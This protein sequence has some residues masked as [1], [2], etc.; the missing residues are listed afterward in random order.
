[1]SAVL[2]RV[3]A[4]AGH[5]GLLAV[6]SLAAALLFSALPRAANEFTDR[7]LREDIAGLP[8]P[9]RDLTFRIAVKNLED[10]PPTAAESGL[11]ELEGQLPAP[12]PGLIGERWFSAMVGPEGIEP[13][14]PPPYA[15]Q[16]RP[17]LQI[18]Y[19]GGYD[20]AVR[21]VTGRL[22]KPG[23]STEVIV[24]S[25]AAELGKLSAGSKLKLAS[26]SGSRPVTVVGVFTPVDRAAHFWDGL[27]TVPASC[28]NPLDGLTSRITM[29]TD[30]S[31]AA[32]AG[33]A[34]EE[35]GYEWRFALAVERLRTSE[36]ASVTKAVADTRRLTGDGQISVNTGLDTALGDFEARLRGVRALLAV[37]Q[38][39]LV[40]TMLGLLVLAARLMT[41]RRR[42]EFALLRA[43]GAGAGAVV[44][45]TL[46]ETALVVP[47]AVLA[48]WALALLVPGRS[49][50]WDPVLVV[51]VGAAALFAAPVLAAFTRG[52]ART[53]RD[54]ARSRPSA[55][56]LT[57]ELFV[58][59]IAVLG[60][61]L[62]RRRGLAGTDSV[63]P[64]LVSVPV[65]LGLAAALIAVRLL[66]W[67]LRQ[68]GRAA[69]RA[70]G[71]VPFLGLAQA[72]RGAPVNV[73]PLAVLV[74][75]VA[76]GV[77]TASVSGTIGAARDQA[78]D[79]EIAADARVD[80]FA[81]DPGTGA[82]LA[83]VAGVDSVAP[84]LTVPA[85]PMTGTSGRRT[86]APLLVVNGV[87]ATKAMAASGVDV[88]MPDALTGAPSGGPAPA[89]VSPTVAAELGGG[90]TIDVQGRQYEFRV[91]AVVDSLPMLDVGGSRFIALPW[92]ALPIPEFQPIVPTRFLVAGD[93][94]STAELRAAG[95]EG[96]RAYL[97]R[98]LGHPV[99]DASLHRR[100]TV[101]TWDEYRADLDKGGVNGVLGFFYAA[102]AAG[103][104]VLA[105]LAVGLAVLADAPGRGRT[106][107]R[108]RTMGLSLRQGRRLLVYE[109]VP[110]VAVAFV[111]GGSV[112]VVLPGLLG[113]ALGLD[114]FTVGV[115]GRI[116]V[117][118]WLPAAA[119][120]LIAAALGLAMLV[121]SMA[122]RRM[123]LGEVL[124]LGEEN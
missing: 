72:G 121:E 73:G 114:G 84:A 45:R 66:P 43:R 24:D 25:D 113:P 96:Q 21:M 80:G 78:T 82:R 123:R 65:L 99:T 70:R 76:T 74:V 56:R 109:L 91:A 102:G 12:L 104:A 41:D 10:L 71:A 22:P 3:R 117:D 38:A 89:V 107:S 39:G 124:R 14:G 77:F 105:L 68:V 101:T 122:N 120:L 48:G 81:F 92:Q 63:D 40:A 75:A 32:Q 6:L 86:Q 58:V 53:R 1:M 11:P 115:T 111:A 31:G 13:S 52:D 8:Y 95:D 29:L 7:G 116:S 67:P 33:K 36:L 27:A 50:P 108:L 44:L 47:A 87:D 20:A 60:V 16:C 51:L 42:D 46:R 100:A 112:G 64:Y 62:V 98:V 49:N 26:S 19:Q 97:S 23:A 69:A 85:A 61:V 17:H 15:G 5:L 118:P 30:M 57:A 79:R 37:V 55:R 54:L 103:A 106:L 34:V 28:P 9:A 93:G 59:G 35:I 94:F 110:L 18:R 88:R 90:G 2:R 119:L 83:A 4:Y